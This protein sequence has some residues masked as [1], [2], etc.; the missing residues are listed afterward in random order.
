MARGASIQG[1]KIV[2]TNHI[3]CQRFN[4]S[5]KSY[6]YALVL[7]ML[8]MMMLLAINCSSKRIRSTSH[9]CA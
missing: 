2:S 4:H 5:G 3:C 6:H 9:D 7:S 8:M 1:T